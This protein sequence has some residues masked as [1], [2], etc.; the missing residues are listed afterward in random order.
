MS[1][2]YQVSVGVKGRIVLPAAVRERT[3]IGEGSQ[4]I[5]LDTESGIVLLTRDELAQRVRD[6]LA[7]LDLVTELLRERRVEAKFYS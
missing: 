4:L 7:G 3:G 5:M 2:T 6:D 1:D